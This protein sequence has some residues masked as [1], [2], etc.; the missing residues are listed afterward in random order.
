MNRFL[1]LLG[2]VCFIP[3]VLAGVNHQSLLAIA[4]GVFAVY[5]WVCGLILFE[6]TPRE[7]RQETSANPSF[8]LFQDYLEARRKIDE[9]DY[10]YNYLF[11]HPD[12]GIWDDDQHGPGQGKR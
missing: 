2:Y 1:F 6:G 12:D 7:L 9:V 10:R 11:N 5:F 3:A 8:E 4:L